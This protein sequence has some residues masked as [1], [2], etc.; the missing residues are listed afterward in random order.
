MSSADS[1]PLETVSG[2]IAGIVFSNRSTGFY[3]LKVVP[4]GK[5]SPVSVLGS[6]PGA[7][8]GVGLKARFQGKYEDH[9]Q[10]GRQLRATAC[11]IVPDKGRSGVVI[12]L[13][14]NVPSI[15]PVTAAKMYD[16]FGDDLLKVLDNEPEKILELGFLTKLQAD[17]IL[18][19]WSEASEAR[20]TSIRLSELGLTGVQMKSVI[21][22]FG[23]EGA[24]KIP[25]ESP[26]RLT[27]CSGI[28]FVTADS[29]ARKV[30]V[31]VD[32]PRRIRAIIMFAMSELSYSDGHL[33]VTRDDIRTFIRK[34]LFSRHHVDRFSGGEEMSDVQF[35]GALVALQESGDVVP[36]G[37]ALY[38]KHNWANES[39]AAEALVEIIAN[40]P[41]G[42]QDLDGILVEFE[43]SFGVTLSDDQRRAFSSLKES[44]V[45][46]VSGYPG[47]GK[48]LLISAF[49]HL[50]ERMNMG[51]NLMSPTGIAAKR[52]SQVTGRPASTIHR[53]LGFK[54]DDWEFNESNPFVVD[55]V[56]VDEMSM[57]DASLFRKLVSSIL[58]TTLLIM[59]GDPAQLPSV[60]AGHVLNS[61]TKCPD[62]SHVALTHI[63]RQ[64]KASDIN[65]VAHAILNGSPID[66]GYRKNSEFVFLEHDEG[67]VMVGVR[68]LTSEM[69]DRG[70]N[71]QV[72]APVYDG[73]L[74]VDSLNHELRGVLNDLILKARYADSCS[75]ALEIAA[76]EGLRSDALAEHVRLVTGR[77]VLNAGSPFAGL[78]YD[79]VHSVILRMRPGS[80]DAHT[81]TMGGIPFVGSK[82]S[83]SFYEGD[84]VMIVKNDYDKMVFNGDVGKVQRISLR[85]N[86]V[87]VKVFNW[88]DP[89]SVVPRWM[90]KVFTFTVEEAR[91]ILKVAYAC[92]AHKV[93]GQ[94]FD[95][96][97]LPMTSKYGIMLYRNL[98]YTAITRAKKKV[99]VFGDPR[100]FLLATRNDREMGRNT[101]LNVLVSQFAGRVRSVADVI[102][103][104]GH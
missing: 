102:S 36:F 78:S 53:A 95:Y 72:I 30:G 43:K 65:T 75:K 29:V 2:K 41:V 58:P 84:R 61:L 8:I 85:D 93:Q 42:F 57:V 81:R 100:A 77:E 60:G 104:S 18:R 86:V 14:A 5:D 98:V 82:D 25:F 26:Y 20:A 21:S 90:D 16:A 49:V 88:L 67:D 12:Y 87:E 19:E 79:E 47:T 32:D 22:K 1:V 13:S 10:H 62:V 11:D 38:L 52:L 56:I 71:F 76:D 4:D 35:W 63:Y 37:D 91:G 92:T 39:G 54:G 89:E 97:V 3:I 17:S 45:L 46:V 51:Y 66:T 94:E 83:P 70:V 69:K 103:D 31:S 48:T 34:K 68:K 40:G 55:A 7:A 59:V 74:G 44:R 80:P 99:F 23:L 96:V 15:G 9:Q 27:E 33:W 28:S 101:M 50:L 24:R 73:V 6:F 64:E